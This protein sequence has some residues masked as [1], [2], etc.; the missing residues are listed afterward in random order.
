MRYIAWQMRYIAWGGIY[1]IYRIE[2]GNH[3]KTNSNF[4]HFSAKKVFM[5][6]VLKDLGKSVHFHKQQRNTGAKLQNLSCDI[7]H[8]S[9]DISHLAMRYNAFGHA[10]YRIWQFPCDI[11]RGPCDVMRCRMRYLK[12]MKQ[13][14]RSLLA[15]KIPVHETCSFCSPISKSNHFVGD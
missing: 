9:C 4:I 10:I 6:F 7:S 8:G 12:R 1:A 15:R 5:C 2:T 3:P 11:S 14:P 13:T